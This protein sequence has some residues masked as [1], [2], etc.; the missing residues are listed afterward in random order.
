M[1]RGPRGPAAAEEEAVT[2]HLPREEPRAPSSSQARRGS[3]EA[4]AWGR[5][6]S[7]SRLPTPRAHELLH[8]DPGPQPAQGTAP[9]SPSGVFLIQACH[10][11]DA[12]VHTRLPRVKQANMEALSKLLQPPLAVLTGST[13]ARGMWTAAWGTVSDA[14]G[15]TARA[16]GA[17]DAQGGPRR[18]EGPFCKLITA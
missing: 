4:S 3:S 11:F 9:P 2:R 12:C 7:P 8:Q 6:A 14:T 10:V 15:T 1:S 13:T 16:R 17:L 18:T 5:A